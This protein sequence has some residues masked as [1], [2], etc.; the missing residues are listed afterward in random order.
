MTSPSLRTHTPATLHTH[1]RTHQPTQRNNNA[2]MAEKKVFRARALDPNRRLA[3]RIRKGG[4]ASA[5]HSVY[6]T[7]LVAVKRTVPIAPSGMEKEEEQVGDVL[8][9]PLSMPQH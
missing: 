5:A 7:P 4:A 2:I 6:A 9:R 1:T 3:V 8:L